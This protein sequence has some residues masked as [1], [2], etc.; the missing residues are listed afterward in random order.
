MGANETGY[1]FGILPYFSN[2][3]ELDY[4]NIVPNP[5]VKNPLNDKNFKEIKNKFKNNK[6]RQVWVRI[7]K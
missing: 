6:S 3:K 4:Q 1:R 7:L 2:I 5:S